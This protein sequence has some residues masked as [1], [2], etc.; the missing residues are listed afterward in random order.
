MPLRP[1]SALQDIA[2]LAR[3]MVL[4]GQMTAS[5]YQQK[6]K[7]DERSPVAALRYLYPR[8]AIHGFRVRGQPT[9]QS[10]LRSDV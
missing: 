4:A 3:C 2:S 9:Y 1:R 5:W 7:S 10:A 8:A 6:R